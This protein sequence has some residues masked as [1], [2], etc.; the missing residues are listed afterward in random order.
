MFGFLLRGEGREGRQIGLPAVNKQPVVPRSRQGRAGGPRARN[1]SATGLPFNPYGT[2][3][4]GPRRN[5]Q[6]EFTKASAFS[7]W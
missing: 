6:P 1:L 7:K 3:I 4:F 2:A 5:A